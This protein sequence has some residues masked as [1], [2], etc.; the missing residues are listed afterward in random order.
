MVTLNLFPGVAQ[1]RFLLAGIHRE[2]KFLLS[3]YPVHL[4]HMSLPMGDTARFPSLCPRA[5]FPGACHTAHAESLHA[6]VWFLSD[7]LA[8]LVM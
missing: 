5:F 3:V 2:V 4:A 7:C 6:R 8:I 1:P